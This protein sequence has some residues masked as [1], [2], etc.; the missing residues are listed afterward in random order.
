MPEYWRLIAGESRVDDNRKPRFY[1]LSTLY[2]GR[3]GNCCHTR[4][5]L[6]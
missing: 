6:K 3:T 4:T 5:A 1:A 2:T